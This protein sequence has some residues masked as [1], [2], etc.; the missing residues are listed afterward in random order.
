MENKFGKKDFKKQP[1]TKK[2]PK[3]VEKKTSGETIKK[4]PDSSCGK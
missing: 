3:K 1:E 2:D 4:Q